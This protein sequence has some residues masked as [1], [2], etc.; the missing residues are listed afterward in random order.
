MSEHRSPS[1]LW[2]EEYEAGGIPSS[3]RA[4]PSGSVVW[5]V[6]ELKNHKARLQT[7][8]DVGCGKGR[9]SLYLAS[10]GMSVT[11]M[12]FTP[13]A[14]SSLAEAASR[15]GLKEKIRQL[16]HDVTEPWPIGRDDV[17]LVV[18]AFCFKHISPLE[19]RIAYK[20]NLLNVLGARGHYMLSFASVGDGYYGRYRQR[21][22]DQDPESGEEVVLDPVNGIASILFTRRRILDFFAPELDLWR[23]VKHNKP[24]TMHGMEYERETYAMLFRREPHHFVG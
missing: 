14:I 19:L 18:D 5:A 23:E 15:F 3:V 10:Q 22:N 4:T 1:E 20:Q 24:V 13:N 17:D 2:N 16:V 12:D 8:V 6:E 7:A 21:P 11:A 9:N